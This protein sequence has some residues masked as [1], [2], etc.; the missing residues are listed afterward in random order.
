M[1]KL[2]RLPLPPGKETLELCPTGSP[3]AGS[4]GTAHSWAVMNTRASNPFP[5][6]LGSH[7]QV[8]M[9]SITSQGLQ[10]PAGLGCPVLPT[11]PQPATVLASSPRCWPDPAVLPQSLGLGRGGP[12]CGLKI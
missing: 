10:V 12:C 6:L 1:G 9:P 2:L 7:S 4:A 8:A 3:S 11:A 5:G